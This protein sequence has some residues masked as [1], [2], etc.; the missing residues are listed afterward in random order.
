MIDADTPVATV[1]GKT[2]DL[3][4]RD[5]LRI[6]K[7]AN[8]EVIA[9][10]IAY[11]KKRVDEVF[12]DA[13]HFFD[14]YAANPE[15]ALECLKAAAEAGAAVIVLCDTRG[16]RMP[17]EVLAATRGAGQAVTTPLGIHCHN[18]SEVAVANTLARRG[19]R[20]YTGARHH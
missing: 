11:L 9:D 4:V 6:S 18:D 20:R 10:S 19:R 2:W 3:H 7:K 15:Y 12:F 13:E 14:G 17:P 8:L 5:D 1:V 16:G